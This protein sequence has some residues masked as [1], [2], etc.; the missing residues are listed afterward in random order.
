MCQQPCAISI[1]FHFPHT[2]SCVIHSLLIS[3]FSVSSI[4]IRLVCLH[5]LGLRNETPAFYLPP[6]GVWLSSMACISTPVVTSLMESL[7]FMHFMHLS[8]WAS[9]NLLAID[10]WSF[11]LLV[12][13]Q[14]ETCRYNAA[15]GDSRSRARLCIS[16]MPGFLC[17]DLGQGKA[18]CILKCHVFV[19]G[20]STHS[21]YSI[22]A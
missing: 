15:L 6:L 22:S 10:H 13:G 1:S 8:A 17:K 19:R 5:I 20:L 21:I 2:V 18:A 12:Q 14:V 11:Y 7:S 4:H 9:E 3:V 16:P